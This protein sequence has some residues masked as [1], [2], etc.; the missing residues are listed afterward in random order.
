MGQCEPLLI[1]SLFIFYPQATTSSRGPCSTRPGI[2]AQV[3]ATSGSRFLKPGASPE[4]GGY[5]SNGN[6]HPVTCFPQFLLER[7]CDDVALASAAG[8]SQS[9]THSDP[10]LH[11]LPI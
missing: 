1:I 2:A 9:V 11:F 6:H 3:T 10:F 7:G 5:L 8:Q 4:Q